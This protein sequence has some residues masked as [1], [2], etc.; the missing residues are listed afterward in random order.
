MG[1]NEFMSKTSK[2]QCMEF[3]SVNGM[4][5][6]DVED[7]KIHVLL[8]F[9]AI[10]T[11]ARGHEMVAQ[12]WAAFEKT[13]TEVGVGELPQ[14]LQYVKTHTTPTPTA[15]PVKEEEEEPMDV[16]VKK[17]EAIV[18]KPIHVSY[19]GGR[20][21]NTGV[22]TVTLPLKSLNQGWMPTFEVCTQRRL[23]C[24]P[25]VHFLRTILVL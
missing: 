9:A 11:V 25:S 2:I 5:V 1:L 16:G 15:T 8:S 17:E 13:C 19:G 10:R 22:A 14:L 24:A 18:E 23:C 3:N 20:Q 12:G 4:H 21:L 7:I 6:E